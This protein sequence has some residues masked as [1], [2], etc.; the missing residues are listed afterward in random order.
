[1]SA[2]L[3]GIGQVTAGTF[4]QARL[5][6]LVPSTLEL[7]DA[8]CAWEL[9]DLEG[10]VWTGGESVALTV[11]ESQTQPGQR[12][13]SAEIQVNV[14]SNVPANVAG[15]QYQL[16]WSVLR[17]GAPALYAFENFLVLPLF[18][19]GQGA[20][21]A[22]ELR[23]DVA[24]V[25]LR[26]PVQYASV[27]YETYRGN[28]RISSPRN[29]TQLAQ[30]STGYIYS[31]EIDPS[32]YGMASLDPLTVVWGYSSNGA[33]PTRETT[34]LFIVTP[35]MLDAV[36]D[37]QTWLNRAYVDSGTAPGTTF[38]PSDYIKHLRAGR[39]AFNA[40]VKPTYFTMTGASGPIRWFWISYSCVSACRAQY[41]AEGM[42][43]FNYAGQTVQLDIDR[44]P[45]WDQAANTLEGT[46]DAQ[47]KTFKDNLAKI[48]ATDGDGGN[49]QGLRPGAVGCIGITL[50]GASSMRGGLFN[51][52]PIG[53]TSPLN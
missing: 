26:L 50:H 45:F 37:M 21:D 5:S 39:D 16:R 53:S 43:A 10:R 40:A 38:Q 13:I 46:L 36:K 25:Q 6:L 49:T 29:A 33:P 52:S 23:G 11:E 7:K 30:D 4:A 51:L 2:F 28:A 27:Y 17:P 41:L 22:I 9:L 14:P 47:V 12:T 1:M 24:F 48:G 34:Q 19:Q 35:V 8:W 44:S 15:S 3:Q 42:K 20:Q 31:G 32:E 18:T